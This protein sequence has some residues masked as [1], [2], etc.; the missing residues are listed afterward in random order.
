MGRLLT[1]PV[2]DTLF[3]LVENL[4][5]W[6]CFPWGEH[7]WTHLYDEIKN[8]I[9]KHSDEHY[10]EMKKDRMYVPTYTLSGFIFAFQ[11][12]CKRAHSSFRVSSSVCTTDIISKKWLKDEVISGLNVR[13][14]KL[15]TIIQVLARERNKEYRG[16]G[17]AP[18]YSDE[19]ISNYFVVEDKL[20][21]CLED[22]ER[23][24]L[25]QEKNILEE[26]RFRVEEVK[27]DLSRLF[28][29]LDTVWLT[30]DIKR[31]IS[32][33]GQVKLEKGWLSKEH[34][35]LWVDYMWYG[36]PDNANWAMVSCYFVQILLQNSTPLFY[37]NGDKYTTPWSDVDQIYCPDWSLSMIAETR[38]TMSG[39]IGS[40]ESKRKL[41]Q[42]HEGKIFS[43][44]KL[45]IV[46][47]R[48]SVQLTLVWIKLQ[49]RLLVI[50]VGAKVFDKKEIDPTEYCIRFKLADDVPKQGD[51][52]GDCGVWHKIIHQVQILGLSLPEEGNTFHNS[53]VLVMLCFIDYLLPRTQ[54]CMDFPHNLQKSPGNAIVPIHLSVHHHSPHHGQSSRNRLAQLN[55]MIS[56]MEA[57][58]DPEEFYDALFCLRDD[59]RDEYNTLMAIND[60]IAKTEEKLSIKEAHR[61]I[62]D[63]EINLWLLYNVGFDQEHMDV[64]D[65]M[66]EEEPV[67]R[68]T[69]ERLKMKTFGRKHI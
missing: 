52:F 37:A 9:E 69:L 45:R 33:Q 18:Y 64:Q 6:N 39:L 16:I 41:Y 40:L 56:E 30:P 48:S 4:E 34:T 17:V 65:Q 14:F 20:R 27:K 66:E 24:R 23:M 35:D 10:F 19:D 36:R 61:E 68:R 53:R 31:F 21:L 62:M 28:H 7:I 49:E 29:S 8:V 15:E 47:L 51:I 32:Q 5:D 43:L 26:K 44:L 13:V 50:L 58:N 1:C 46:M 12:S 25:D 59:K 57:M 38:M 11:K 22:E 60:V 63:A 2:D 67:Q 55:D 54:T 42:G 3:Q